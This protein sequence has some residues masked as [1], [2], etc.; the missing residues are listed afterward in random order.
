MAITTTQSF[1]GKQ[2]RVPMCAICKQR[3]E[4]VLYT[5]TPMGEN[6]CE[7][8]SGRSDG[9]IKVVKDRD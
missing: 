2:S 8:C 9:L 6:V 7:P 4:G 1:S 3:V 5:R